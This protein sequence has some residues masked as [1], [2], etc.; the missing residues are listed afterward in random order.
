MLESGI[1]RGAG[2]FSFF[3]R[4]GILGIRRLSLE[5]LEFDVT[6]H[7]DGS[8]SHYFLQMRPLGAEFESGDQFELNLQRSADVPSAAFEIFPGSTIP[9]GRHAWSRVEL[10]FTSSNARTVGIR[11]TGSSGGF[12]DGHSSEADAAVDIRLAPHLTSSLEYALQAVTRAVG[13]FTARTVRLRLDLA[14]SPRLGGTMFIQ[15]DNA[16]DR[17]TINLRLHWIPRPGSDAYLVY[18]S[19]WPTGS[20]GGIPWSRPAAGG[21]VAKFVYYVRG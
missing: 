13:D 4:P 16:S 17:L 10:V 5:P 18:N 19:A 1:W 9:A 7:L 21:L 12:Y 20:S 2:A 11:F 3:P 8:L 15:Q 6:D 14:A